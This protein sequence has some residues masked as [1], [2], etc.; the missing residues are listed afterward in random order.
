[1]LEGK[2]RWSSLSNT[3]LSLLNF[4]LIKKKKEKKKGK[5][6]PKNE[7]ISERK[8]HTNTQKLDRNFSMI[9]DVFLNQK[10][11]M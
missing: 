10:K 2:E 5:F 4:S 6:L 8:S 3:N 9:T 1:M 7:E 11:L